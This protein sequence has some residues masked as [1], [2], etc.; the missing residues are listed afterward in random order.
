MRLVPYS[1]NKMIYQNR[2]A[3]FFYIRRI[4]V[5][6]YFRLIDSKSSTTSKSLRKANDK[7]RGNLFGEELLK[8]TGDVLNNVINHKKIKP[9]LKTQA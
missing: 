7:K 1:C 3:L 6:K 9:S 2:L 5:K 8:S 4:G